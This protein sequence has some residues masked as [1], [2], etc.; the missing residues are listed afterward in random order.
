MLDIGCGHGFLLN[1][2]RELGFETYGV[3]LQEA[4]ALYAKNTF[5][6]NV[7][8]VELMDAHYLPDFFDVVVLSSVLEHLI[9]PCEI[10]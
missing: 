4:S 8:T 10:L 1:L 5:G 9:N 7:L 2:S 6:L 3:E